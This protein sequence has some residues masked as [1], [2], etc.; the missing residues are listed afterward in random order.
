MNS[1][2]AAVDLAELAEAASLLAN[3]LMDCCG[4]KC[5]KGKH[6]ESPPSGDE[7]FWLH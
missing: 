1:S 2:I 4:P 5:N 7:V 6:C 3:V